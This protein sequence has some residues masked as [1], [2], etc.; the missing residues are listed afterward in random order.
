[1]VGSAQ[2][3]ASDGGYFKM[4]NCN[5][6]NAHRF[7]SLFQNGMG[8]YFDASI[9][10][11]EWSSL[12]LYV[13]SV[14]IPLLHARARYSTT[15][16]THGEYFYTD[17][18]RW[19]DVF[20]DDSSPPPTT[21]NVT[22]AVIVVRKGEIVYNG[23]VLISWQSDF[24]GNVTK[25]QGRKSSG[26]AVGDWEIGDTIYAKSIQ[27]KSIEFNSNPHDN[28]TQALDYNFMV[29]LDGRDM[30]AMHGNTYKLSLIHI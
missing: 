12:G 26:N 4:D 5:F 15:I 13:E 1:M 29:N 11:F 3:L 19:T 9:C 20:K 17:A 28:I 6:T 27:G 2:D 14:T 16:P 18:T 8:R 7:Y 10:I 22:K 21:S 25:L 30:S 24:E 23:D